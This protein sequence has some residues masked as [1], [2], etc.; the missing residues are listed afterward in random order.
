MTEGVFSPRGGRGDGRGC[1]VQGGTSEY[2][3]FGF[4]AKVPGREQM[5]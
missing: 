1:L 4:S 5:Y 2:F 3:W